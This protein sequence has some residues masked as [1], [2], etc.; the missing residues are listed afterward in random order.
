MATNNTA[1]A[2][3]GGMPQLDFST[4]P[5]QAFWLVITL[6]CLFMMVRLLVIPRMDNI[7]ANRRKV[8][9]EDLVGAEK[10]RDAAEE[11]RNALTSEVDSAR[12]RSNE[13]LSKTKQKSKSNYKKGMAE[14]SEMTT[15]LLVDSDKLIGK[16]Q[17]DAAQQVDQI[18]D[19]IVPELIE[20]MSH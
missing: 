6:L 19:E 16:M 5:N 8:I 12:T 17:K 1:E 2:S 15:K 11:L 18:S 14:A 9:E 20:K 3:S 10:F 7:L 4:F 13:I